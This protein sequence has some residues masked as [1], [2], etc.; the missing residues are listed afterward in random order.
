V[1]IVS[2]AVLVP[3]LFGKTTKNEKITRQQRAGAGNTPANI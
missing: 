1:L 3:G 2:L